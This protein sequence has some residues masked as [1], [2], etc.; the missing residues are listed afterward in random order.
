MAKKD[1]G[2]KVTLPAIGKPKTKPKK[3]SAKDLGKVAN[4][5]FKQ[6]YNGRY[7]GLLHSDV[8]LISKSRS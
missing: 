8:M 7:K 3:T 1:S 2:K 4:S 6:G 5:Q